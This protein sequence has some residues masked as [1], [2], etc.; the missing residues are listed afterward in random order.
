MWWTRISEPRDV[1]IERAPVSGAA[2]FL[3][4]DAGGSAISY[5]LKSLGE[6]VGRAYDCP[7]P[8]AWPW[9]HSTRW[10]VVTTQQWSVVA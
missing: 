5:F 7:W 9:A 10:L 1:R 6:E 8:W 2:A 3:R 4:S